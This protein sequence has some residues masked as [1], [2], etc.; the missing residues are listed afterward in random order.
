MQR[1]LKIHHTLQYSEQL[2]NRTVSTEIAA[3]K[4]KVATCGGANS[5]ELRAQAK[6]LGVW[7]A[8]FGFFFKI[9]LLTCFQYLKADKIHLS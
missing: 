9:T 3:L 1:H 2:Q 4:A 6:M 7:W 5:V 8:C